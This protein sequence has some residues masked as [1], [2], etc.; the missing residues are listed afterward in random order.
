M[1]RP[2]LWLAGGMVI[3]GGLAV[4]ALVTFA[5]PGH[6]P[7]HFGCLHH[8][9]GPKWHADHGRALGQPPNRFARPDAANPELGD[10]GITSRR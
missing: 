3:A 6:R 10:R 1:R 4:G 2:L 9:H 7:L 5:E 8:A